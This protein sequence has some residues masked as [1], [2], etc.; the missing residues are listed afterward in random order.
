[1]KGLLSICFF[2]LLIYGCDF[3]KS[4]VIVNNSSRDISVSYKIDTTFFSSGI[5]HEP[6]EYPGNT[7]CKDCYYDS[8]T[9]T[10]NVTLPIGDSINIGITR[11]PASHI[12]VLKS[13]IRFFNDLDTVRKERFQERI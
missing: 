4:I 2:S 3:Y 1:M 8:T 10:Y 11:L 6:F 7:K 12:Y 13:D 9:N 5:M